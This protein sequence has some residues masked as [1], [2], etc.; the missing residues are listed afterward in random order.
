MFNGGLNLDNLFAGRT[1]R[2]RVLQ[3]ATLL[4]VSAAIAACGRPNQQAS[5]S[6]GI[7]EVKFT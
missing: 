1:S 5:Q 6:T 2:R 3:Q 4:G 7:R